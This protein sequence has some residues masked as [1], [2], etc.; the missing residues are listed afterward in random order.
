MHALR[1]MSQ[2]IRTIKGLVWPLALITL[3]MDWTGD[4]TVKTTV[5]DISNKTFI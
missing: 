5:K 1:C 2:L 4:G 3:G